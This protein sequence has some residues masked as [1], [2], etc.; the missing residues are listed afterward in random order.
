MNV[1]SVVMEGGTGSVADECG[2]DEFTEAV[3]NDE[4]AD[5]DAGAAVPTMTAGVVQLFAYF[6]PSRLVR[7]V[8]A[9]EEEG[10]GQLKELLGGWWQGDEAGCPMWLWYFFLLQR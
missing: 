6:A 8:E 3:D 9:G 5:E 10:R 1:V 7:G 4:E 2:D